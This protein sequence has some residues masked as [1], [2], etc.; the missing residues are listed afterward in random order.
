M[1]FSIYF[2]SLAWEWSSLKQSTISETKSIIISKSKIEEI[3][4]SKKNDHWVCCEN[5][6]FI[7]NNNCIITINFLLLLPFLKVRLLNR[8]DSLALCSSQLYI[9]GMSWVHYSA[10]VQSVQEVYFQFRFSKHNSNKD[11]L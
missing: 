2:L 5:Y 8:S 7:K 9:N 10:R 4:E 3:F 6:T 1:N 11:V